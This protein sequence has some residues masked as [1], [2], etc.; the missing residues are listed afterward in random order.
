MLLLVAVEHDVMMTDFCPLAVFFLRQAVEQFSCS[1]FHVWTSLFE[2]SD[3]HLGCC[4]LVGNCGFRGSLLADAIK[5][6]TAAAVIAISDVI[7][8]IMVDIIVSYITVLLFQIS[9]IE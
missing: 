4:I 2:I 8:F 1:P 7:L 9:T 6:V 3:K 5:E